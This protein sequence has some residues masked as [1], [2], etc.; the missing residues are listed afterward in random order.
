MKMRIVD[1]GAAKF[2][3]SEVI[4]NEPVALY[5]VNSRE[6]CRPGVQLQLQN[7]LHSNVS[8]GALLTRSG[9]GLSTISQLRRRGRN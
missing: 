6:M 3:C 5:S 2:C 7:H 1:A 4:D 8:F 9:N